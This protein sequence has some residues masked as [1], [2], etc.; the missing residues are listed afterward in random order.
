MGV[1]VRQ[2]IYVFEKQ[3]DPAGR[4]LSGTLPGGNSTF[5]YDAFGRLESIVH[6]SGSGNFQRDLL[7]R[8]TQVTWT[9]ATPISQAMGFDLAGN[10]TQLER[11]NTAASTI[12]YDAVDQVLSSVGGSTDVRSYTR[13]LLGN[14]LQDSVNG[15]GSFVSNFLASN[16]LAAYTADPNGFG[17]TVQEVK[18]GVTKNYVYRADGLLSGFQSGST[19]VASYYD[20]LGRL[21]A[22]AINDGVNNFTQS[23]AYLGAESTLLQAKAGDGTITSFL[24][25]Q[26]PN[27]YLAESKGGVYKGYLTDHA[28]SILNS[29]LAGPAHRYSLHGEPT[30]S[31]SLSPTSSPAMLGWQGLRF[32]PESGNWDNLAREYNPSLG[33]FASQDP[34]GIDGG[35]NLYGSRNYNPLR[36]VDPDGESPRDVK[37]I[38]DIYQAYVDQKTR[39]GRRMSPGWENN[40]R[41]YA[42]GSKF[43]GCGEQAFTLSD[44][45]NQ[46]VADKRFDDHWEFEIEELWFETVFPLHQRVVGLPGNASDPVL[47]IDP[48]R[49]EFYPRKKP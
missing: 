45:L 2:K 4:M 13:D 16:G 42:P 9:G 47:V 20:A 37:L 12:A 23:Y 46:A 19:Q 17:E 11:E 30:G 28:G 48:H 33:I 6:P 41:S 10:I 32:N 43:E 26:G 24:S 44:I 18:A 8:I 3:Y 1:A 34:S 25:G 15:A 7:N 21:A 39:E 38:H 14:R 49:P 40:F 5:G 35:I 29:E 36:F 22:R 27:E 31:V